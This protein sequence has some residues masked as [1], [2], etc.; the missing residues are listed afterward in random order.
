MPPVDC[1]CIS[2][3]KTPQLPEDSTTQ[4]SSIVIV[5]VTHVPALTSWTSLVRPT[6][7]AALETN[8]NNLTSTAALPAVT[9]MHIHLLCCQCN[10]FH[11]LLGTSL[12]STGSVLSA[13]PTACWPRL[14]C[15]CSSLAQQQGQPAA[16]DHRPA[17]LQGHKHKFP[18]SCQTG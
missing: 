7:P 9:D 18:I 16:P 11:P 3:I 4:R 15:T 10:C 17:G 5:I 12:T 14:R 6:Q 8:V 1:C 2:L 13:L